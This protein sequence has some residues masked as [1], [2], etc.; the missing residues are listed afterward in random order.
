MPDKKSNPIR[1]TN[2]YYAIGAFGAALVA[3]SFV[4]GFFLGSGQATAEAGG[5][6]LTLSTRIVGLES[7]PPFEV[8]EVDFDEFWEVWR[9]VKE[10]YVNQ[11]EAVDEKMF[12]GALRGMVASLDDPYS[13]FLEPTTAKAFND[14]LAGTFEGIG[15][16]IGIKKGQLLIVAPLPGTPADRAGVKAGDYILSVDEADTYGMTIDEAVNRIRGKKGTVV[17]L[18]LLRKGASEAIDV[19]ITRG[20][21]NVDSVRWRIEEINDGDRL[22]VISI[23]NFNEDTG[24]LFSEAVRAMLLENVNGVVL[25]LRNNPGGYLDMAVRVASEWVGQNTVVVESFSDGSEKQHRGVSDARLSDMPT[26]VLV[27]GGSASA[28][29]IVA[30]ALQD[31]GKAEIIGEK[32]YGKGSVQDYSE[33]IDGSA[34]KLTVALWLTPSGRSINKEGIEPTIDVENTAGDWDNDLDPQFDKAVHFLTGY[35][36]ADTLGEDG[37]PLNSLAQEEGETVETQEE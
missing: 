13:V 33:F 23:S 16:E 3:L 18:L 25:D 35:V 9:M 2:R 30:G 14:D 22:G 6:G 34:L 19:P 11:N 1:E 21:I 27:N 31:A 12:Y 29:E 24:P 20:T 4:A 8:K 15:A 28:S 37:T 5:A 32:T 7:N 36:N 26:V 17:N 10:K